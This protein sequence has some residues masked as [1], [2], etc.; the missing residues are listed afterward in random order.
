MGGL[1]LLA[2]GLVFGQTVHFEFV[3]FDDGEYVY[4]NPLVSR[5]LRAEAITWA[6]THR[7][8]ANWHPLTW[9]SLMLDCQSLA[10]TPALT[11]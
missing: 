5:R 9:L 7:H 2:V 11:I 10:R 1:L 4:Q 8:S 3:N 6:F